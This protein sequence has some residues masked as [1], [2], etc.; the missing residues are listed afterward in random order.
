MPTL[1]VLDGS[2][3]RRITWNAERLAQDDP[4]ARAAVREAEGIFARERAR[5]ALAF[6]VRPGSPAERIEALDPLEEE[7][8]LL[9][10]M[11]GG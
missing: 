6:R 7:T 11:V 1:R 3:D 10:P 5:G 9:P 8:L 4:E 2:G